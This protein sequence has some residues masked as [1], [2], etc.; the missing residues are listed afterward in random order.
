MEKLLIVLE[1]L[2]KTKSVL[3]VKVKLLIGEVV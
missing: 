3:G 2:K 1:T